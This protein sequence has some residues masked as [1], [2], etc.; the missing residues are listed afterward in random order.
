MLILESL[1][2]THVLSQESKRLR[3]KEKGGCEFLYNNA[4]ELFVL[5]LA[6]IFS[7]Y[8]CLCVVLIVWKPSAKA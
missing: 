5:A 2:G 1:P 3:K 4:G 7:E 6:T 8:A